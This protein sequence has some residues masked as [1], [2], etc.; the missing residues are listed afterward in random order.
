[1]RRA[2]GP[3]SERAG[4]G[5]APRPVDSV[6]V[7][8]VQ[9]VDAVLQLV[10][11][12]ALV[13]AE[14]KEADVGVQGELVHRVDAAHVIEHEEQHRGPLGARAVSLWKGRSQGRRGGARKG[15]GPEV[16]VAHLSGQVDVDLRSFTGL[17]LFGHLGGGY[18]G[19]PQGVHQLHVI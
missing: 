11:A 12:M 9:V 3:H 19:G 7:V 16:D 1:M 10:A 14:D 8:L 13:D 2:S 5:E 15:A 17:Q 18:L 4:R 6:G